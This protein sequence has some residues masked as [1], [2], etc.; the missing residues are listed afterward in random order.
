MIRRALVLLAA[1][2]ALLALPTVAPA[3]SR[4]GPVTVLSGIVRPGDHAASGRATIVRYPSGRRFLRLGPF[5]LSPGPVTRV[6][7][8]P[9][10]ARTDR[11]AASDY[12]SLGPLKSA[13]GV[14]QYEIGRTVNLARYRSVVFWCVPFRVILARADLRAP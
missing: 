2:V 10:G 14:Q 9:A 3:A 5:S 1:A 11:A 4:T 12:R 8:V 6:W 7:L 13:R